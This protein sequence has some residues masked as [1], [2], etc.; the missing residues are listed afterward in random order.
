MGDQSPAIYIPQGVEL[1]ID[2]S[3]LLQLP[4]G[5]PTH[6]EENTP[7]PITSDNQRFLLWRDF[8][9]L[10]VVV[11]VQKV[12]RNLPNGQM[13]WLCPIGEISLYFLPHSRN[14]K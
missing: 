13:F 12:K 10:P 3:P 14:R 11:A 5:L 6:G 7:E 8:L 1:I 2:W 4:G 9:L